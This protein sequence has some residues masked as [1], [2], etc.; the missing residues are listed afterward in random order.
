M[1]PLGP[2]CNEDG[3][4]FAR[5]PEALDLEEGD[6]FAL[7]RRVTRSSF[8]I[9]I[10]HQS[11]RLRRATLVVRARMAETPS[12]CEAFTAPTDRV[13]MRLVLGAAVAA[14]SARTDRSPSPNP[15]ASQDKYDAPTTS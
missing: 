13:K 6:D 4:F 15:P 2:T 5:A 11:P 8:I 7:Q 14:A 10:G 1:S 12:R 3:F 9:G